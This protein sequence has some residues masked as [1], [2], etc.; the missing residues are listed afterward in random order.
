[1]ESTTTISVRQT[2]GAFFHLDE[3]CFPSLVA[4]S[5]GAN[6]HSGGDEVVFFEP[7]GSPSMLTLTY[8]MI[9]LNGQDLFVGWP[10]G[11]SRFSVTTNHGTWGANNLPKPI[12]VTN[13]G[14]GSPPSVT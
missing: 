3:D 7:Q 11:T 13:K 10:N 1:M 4:S 6:Y 5:E 12:V 9:G 14:I 2:L 8:S